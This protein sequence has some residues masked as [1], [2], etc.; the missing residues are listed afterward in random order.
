MMHIAYAFITLGHTLISAEHHPYVFC[1][2]LIQFRVA[3]GLE[4]IPAV[5]GWEA[6]YTLDMSSVHHRDT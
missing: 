1:T 5:I 4:L 2:G 3:G 6:G